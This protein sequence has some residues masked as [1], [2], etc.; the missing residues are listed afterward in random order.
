MRLGRGRGCGV[1]TCQ[2]ELGLQSDDPDPIGTIERSRQHRR[3]AARGATGT[4]VP[5]RYFRYAATPASCAQTQCDG[6]RT[7]QVHPHRTPRAT[8]YSGASAPEIHPTLSPCAARAFAE[9]THPPTARAQSAKC[10]RHGAN[11]GAPIPALPQIVAVARGEARRKGIGGTVFASRR[12]P[13]LFH[14]SYH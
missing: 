14:L 5:P 2:D 12:V 1:L 4:T 13:F 7:A 3:V 6:T 10:A 9:V 8:S 11:A